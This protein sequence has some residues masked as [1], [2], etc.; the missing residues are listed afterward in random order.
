MAE[1]IG[2]SLRVIYDW[3]HAWHDSGIAGLLGDLSFA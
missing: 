1:E 3:I 2:C